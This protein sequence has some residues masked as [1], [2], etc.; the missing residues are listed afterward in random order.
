[1]IESD[2]GTVALLPVDN[3]MVSGLEFAEEIKPGK[4]LRK[5]DEIGCFLFGGSDI[6]M[7]FEGK[8][9]FT[10]TEKPAGEANGHLLCGE[11]YGR[12]NVEMSA[13][14]PAE[15]APAETSTSTPAE[16]AVSAE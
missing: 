11:E 13:A 14:T 1:M 8:A 3:G 4:A 5:G 15:A 16:A 10:L 12:V 9:G 6:V 7:L 2:A